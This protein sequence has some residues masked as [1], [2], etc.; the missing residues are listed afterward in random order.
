M[1]GAEKIPVVSEYTYLGATFSATGKFDSHVDT[2]VSKA[3]GASIQRMR[4]AESWIGRDTSVLLPQLTQCFAPCLLWATDVISLT[5][6]EISTLDIAFFKFLRRVYRVK[7]DG[8]SFTKTNKQLLEL[9]KIKPPS[10]LL[11]LAHLKF[12]FHLLSAESEIEP[13]PYCNGFIEYPGAGK[14]GNDKFANLAGT[15]RRELHE[16]NILH[17]KKS[18]LSQPLNQKNIFLECSRFNNS[19]IASVL[20]RIFMYSETISPQLPQIDPAVPCAVFATDASFL[21]TEYGPMASFAIVDTLG[22]SSF[23]VVDPGPDPSSTSF[24]LAAIRALLANLLRTPM[25]NK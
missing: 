19:M 5:Q 8:T 16:F 12:F 10:E 24:E 4:N 25:T 9:S 11:P 21:K 13:E 14:Q 23:E 1:I 22:H 3:S 6:S 2:R 18:V 20:D 15:L 17:V 7:F